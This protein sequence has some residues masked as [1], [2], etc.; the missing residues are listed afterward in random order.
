MSGG[1]EFTAH[2]GKAMDGM[3]HQSGSQ[4]ALLDAGVSSDS[5]RFSGEVETAF[6]GVLGALK[7]DRRNTADPASEQSRDPHHMD[8]SPI[9]ASHRESPGRAPEQVFAPDRS[10]ESLPVLHPGRDSGP[11]IGELT[12]FLI[13][14]LEDARRR[15]GAVDARH[16]ITQLN[17]GLR[18][19]ARLQAYGDHG[20]RLEEMH[21]FLHAM[22]DFRLADTAGRHPV[23]EPEGAGALGRQGVV[24]QAMLARPNGVASRFEP[25]FNKPSSGIR[26]D[27][28]KS[29]GS[30]DFPERGGTISFSNRRAVLTFGLPSFGR[31]YQLQLSSNRM[32]A[33]GP[34]TQQSARLG[35]GVAFCALFV[36]GVLLYALP[37]LPSLPTM[38]P[39]SL[40]LSEPEKAAKPDVRPTQPLVSI[41]RVPLFEERGSAEKAPV[42]ES[43][44]TVI[45]APGHVVT[46]STTNLRARPEQGAQVVRVVPG[47]LILTVFAHNDDW[48]QVGGTDAWGWVPSSLISPLT[49]KSD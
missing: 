28:N 30:L 45:P 1:A 15:E 31:S 11:S 48:V 17:E 22:G 23:F 4:G 8:I 5:A 27:L 42:T 26:L 25:G 49:P 37:R 43:P 7:V 40:A 6:K 10:A 21:A 29:A 12:S 13:A 35:M 33:R 46:R 19:R 14:G 32:K 38:Q 3:S 24:T 34:E 9:E 18:R 36:A 41:M 20:G 16:I 2:Q 44:P 39:R 47:R